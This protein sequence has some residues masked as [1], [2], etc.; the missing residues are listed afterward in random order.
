MSQLKKL[1]RL[2]RGGLDE[3]LATTIE[4]NGIGDI[5]KYVNTPFS[6]YSNLRIVQEDICDQRLPK[7]WGVHRARCLC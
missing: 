4:V 7:E 1:F 6:C 3:S 5:E 2:H